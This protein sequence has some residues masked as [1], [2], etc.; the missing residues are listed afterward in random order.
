VLEVPILPPPGSSTCAPRCARGGMQGDA[1]FTQ[2]SACRRREHNRDEAEVVYFGFDLQR[3]TACVGSVIH[4][5]GSAIPLRTRP[6]CL[7]RAA[8]PP[9]RPGACGPVAG[10]DRLVPSTSVFLTI[11]MNVG[12]LSTYLSPLLAL[13]AGR[14]GSARP[15]N[16]EA[17]VSPTFSTCPAPPPHPPS[18]SWRAAVPVSGHA[19]LQLARL[20]LLN[21][22][23]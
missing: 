23:I 4:A 8:P 20:S 2:D 3:T 1:V 14:G 16:P 12:I 19:L 13:N 6:S 18:P 21:Y 15:I 5:P 10:A 9:A 11:I 22:S 17:P 7:R